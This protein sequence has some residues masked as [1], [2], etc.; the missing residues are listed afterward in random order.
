MEAPYEKVQTYDSE[1][2]KVSM[3][4]FFE[5]LGVFGISDSREA[6]DIR[7]YDSER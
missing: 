2:S 3:I 5:D 1:T 7:L 6:H 4:F